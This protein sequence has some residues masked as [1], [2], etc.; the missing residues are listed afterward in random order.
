[1]VVK[2]YTIPI[3]HSARAAQ[4]MLERKGTRHET[5]AL[6]SG[7][8]PILLR[9]AGFRGGTVPALRVDGKRVQGSLSISRFLDAMQPDPP[10][11]PE[12]PRLRSSVEEAERWG[13]NVLQPVPRR[14]YRWALVRN[15]EV[16][17]ELV[18]ANRIP[19]AAVAIVAMKPLAAY[20]ARHSGADEATVRRH[21]TELPRLLD[22]ADE[23][24]RAGVL[25]SHTP[26]AAACQIAPS[27]RLLLNFVQ[28]QPLFSDRPAADFARRMLPDYP[29]LVPAVFPPSWI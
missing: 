24:V 13:A 21:L 17:R 29:G 18:L 10:L 9:L 26:N 3:S 8:H 22:H 11:F 4:L 15:R 27:L 16:R 12:D 7:L 25:G 20:F 6:L 28:L 23:L 19:I 2:L 14:L 1:V 5:V